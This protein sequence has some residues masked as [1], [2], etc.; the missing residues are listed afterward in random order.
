MGKDVTTIQQAARDK[1]AT[2]DSF[3]VKRDGEGKLI[4]IEC[5]TNYGTIMVIPMTY[6]DA[7]K[8]A[9]EMKGSEDVTS[10]AIADQFK[11]FIVEPDMS[12]VTGDDIKQN[13]KPLVVRDLINA[14]V[15]VSG[16][17]KEVNATVN[18]DGT[19]GIDM[20]KN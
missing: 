12:G 6:G 13:F 4:P 5:E 9:E 7:E 3:R 2:M 8:W 20:E 11:Q 18:A 19:V 17:E 10:E 15:R 14:I 1:R 16:L